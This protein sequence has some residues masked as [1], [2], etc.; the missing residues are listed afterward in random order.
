MQRL[1]DGTPLVVGAGM[2]LAYDGLL[3]MAF[4]NVRPP[5]ETA[6]TE[7]TRGR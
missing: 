1:G 6:R 5:E 4:R 2:K 7:T 3:W